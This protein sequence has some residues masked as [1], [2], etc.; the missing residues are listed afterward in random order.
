MGSLLMRSAVAAAIAAISAAAP[1]WGESDRHE[2]YFDASAGYVAAST[3]LTAWTKGGFSKLRYDEDGFEAF[4][5]F[6]EYHGRI[7]PTL[8]ARVVADYVD[9]ASSGVGVTEAVVEWRPVP[10]SKNQQQVRFGAF[11]PSFSLENGDP[12]VDGRVR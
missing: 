3:D 6:G 8:R 11:Y 4:R 5:L 9:D 2:F 7:T 1:A 12:R 10:H